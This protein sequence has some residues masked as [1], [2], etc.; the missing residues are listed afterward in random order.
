MSCYVCKVCR[1]G[2]MHGWGVAAIGVG[3]VGLAANQVAIWKS[4]ESQE[5]CTP[6]GWVV[7]TGAH[8]AMLGFSPAHPQEQPND[9][10]SAREVWIW[11]H[12]KINSHSPTM[13]A[14]GRPQPPQP[15]PMGGRSGPIALVGNWCTHHQ[16]TVARRWQKS[17]FWPNLACQGLKQ[18]T[19]L[20]TMAPSGAGRQQQ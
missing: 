14:S 6:L 9:A 15:D 5:S 20:L 11:Q 4:W 2:F 10:A 19:W 13:G 1:G 16:P 12:C 3:V 7:A 17:A 8:P 18:A